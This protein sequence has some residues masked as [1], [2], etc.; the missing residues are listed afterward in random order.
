MNGT[1][2]TIHKQCLQFKKGG[3]SLNSLKNWRPRHKNLYCRFGRVKKLNKSWKVWKYRSRGIL[4][5]AYC[6]SFQNWLV[7]FLVDIF[8]QDIYL[9]SKFWSSEKPQPVW[10]W[11][12]GPILTLYFAQMEAGMPNDPTLHLIVS[13]DVLKDYFWLDLFRYLLVWA[14]NCKSKGD[15]FQ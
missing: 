1:K 7:N 13:Y 14:S 9:G 8:H 2:G 10:E 4:V 12:F 11:I 15:N 6:L 5:C 3:W